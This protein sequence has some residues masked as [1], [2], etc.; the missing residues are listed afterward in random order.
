VRRGGSWWRVAAVLHSHLARIE[1]DSGGDKTEDTPSH[2]V[3]VLDHTQRDE[4]GRRGTKN[5]VLS[6]KAGSYYTHGIDGGAVCVV[7]C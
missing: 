1:G 3:S 4:E 6:T 5:I 7:A 2:D